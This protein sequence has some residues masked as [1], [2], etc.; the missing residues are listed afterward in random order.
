MKGKKLLAGI[1]SAAMVL[2]TMAFPAFADDSAVAKIGEVEYTTLKEAIAEA[3][4]GETVT[5]I[6]DASGDGIEIGEAKNIIIDFSGFTY[7]VTAN[8]VGSSGTKTNAFRFL[9]NSNVTLKNGTIKTG[10]SGTAILVQNYSD[11]TLEDMTLDFNKYLY[12]AGY[13][14]S[15]NKGNTTIKGKTQIISPQGKNSIASKKVY[16]LNIY[17]DETYGSVSL[18]IDDSM[19][20][21]I[22][23]NI[24]IS[25]S[26]VS[27]GTQK[28]IIKNGTYTG[29][30]SDKRTD[31]TINVAEIYGGT[32][33]KDVSEYCPSGCVIEKNDDGTM[34]VLSWTTDTDS[35]SY[36]SGGDTLGMMRFMFKIEPTGTVTDSGIKYINANDISKSVTATTTNGATTFQG[37]V[38]KV[39][40]DTTGTYYARAY[41]TTDEGTFWSEPV[42]CSVNWNQ[43]FT[44]YTGGAQ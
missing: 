27:E 9:E 16:A 6:S 36:K 29:T 8:L 14:L 24:E 18:T 32:F 1:I 44:D 11:L 10:V 28:L 5:L 21:K 37:D 41:I 38:V 43:F 2:C 20:G 39:P 3:Q 4:N 26:T 30:I 42:G 19:T 40:T 17:N 13:T 23:G 33:S 15:C 35:G 7:T 25:G 22:T 31:K 34:T 12:T